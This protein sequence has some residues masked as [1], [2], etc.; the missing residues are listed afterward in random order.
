MEK[1]IRYLSRAFCVVIVTAVLV[2]GYFYTALPC[3]ISVETG[4][5]ISGGFLG[6]NLKSTEGGCGYYLGNIPIKTAQAVPA[7]RPMLIPC[8]TPFGIK[9][10]TDGVMVI[11]VTENSP[12][13]ESGICEGDIIKT[14][15]G[16]EV[17]TNSEISQAIQLSPFKS[18][19]ILEHG[20]SQKRVICTPKQDELGILKI[21]VW[22]RDS[23][24]GIGTMTYYDPET[25]KCGGLG[26]P[27][28]DVTT[29]EMMP[30]LSGEIT[31]AN[32]FGVVKGE[33]GTAGELCG[34][35]A[36]GDL[37]K[38]SQNTAVGIFG[39]MKAPYDGT[40]I[41]MA[42]KQEVYCGEASILSTID[43]NSP[44]EFKIEIERIN[45]YDINGSK[46]MVIRIT[47][48]ELLEKTGGIVRG[49]SGSPIIQDGKLVGAVTHV[50]INDPSRG[51]AVFCESMINESESSVLSPAA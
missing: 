2:M 25:G 42:F 32:I 13:E 30:L 41:P 39:T 36:E 14:V 45:I 26:H 24:A 10:R 47:D 35:L 50:F 17:K 12:A 33:H 44:K 7:E 3:R 1:T 46:S 15:N 38:I 20:S 23:A 51:Y 8:G 5:E 11:T 40:P 22:V 49:M 43:G 31:K 37:G 48:E 19:I 21:G 29:G 6:T 9:L 4:A 34:E 27:V 18:E 28:S 16:M